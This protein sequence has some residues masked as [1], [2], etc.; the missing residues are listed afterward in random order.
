M[1]VLQND[2]SFGAQGRW[3]YQNHIIVSLIDG[4]FESVTRLGVLNGANV[5]VLES[6]N[7]N[8][9]LI[10]F[11]QAELQA[12]GSWKLSR[13]LRA[14]LGTEA[15]M[16]A[17]SFVGANVILLNQAIYPLELKDGE[18]GILQDWRAGPAKDHVSASTY[19]SITHQNNRRSSQ[20]FSPVHLRAQITSD[21][22]YEV[23]WIRR[24]RINSDSW[25][26]A[27][28]PLDAQAEQ[29]LLKIFDLEG[30]MKREVTV[31]K[32][33]FSYANQMHDEDLGPE[34]SRFKI[35]VSQ[36]NDEGLPG[37]STRIEI[38]NS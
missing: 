22:G 18:I 20:L 29:Y 7:G 5:I 3:D 8:Y 33:N 14:Q 25:D 11:A 34:N 13:L 10:Q 31:L 24:G 36:L 16:L 17:G 26:G 32:P 6:N 9:E 27:D 15:E 1:G 2:I 19:N 37:A 35:E 23:S 38:S 21:G 12:D 28:I 30:N 4:N